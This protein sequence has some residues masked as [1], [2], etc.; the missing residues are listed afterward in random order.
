MELRRAANGDDVFVYTQA[1]GASCLELQRLRRTP[2]A[3]LIMCCIGWG[4]VPPS[5][6]SGPQTQVL[7][8]GLLEKKTERGGDGP[9]RP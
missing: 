3:G 1:A 9:S 7:P 6:L 8:V 5:P 4:R 2:L